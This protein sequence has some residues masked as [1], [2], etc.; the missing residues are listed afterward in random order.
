MAASSQGN[1]I[2]SDEN[3]EDDEDGEDDDEHNTDVD[4]DDF[5]KGGRPQPPSQRRGQQTGRWHP[6][7]PALWIW[8]ETYISILILNILLQSY[9]SSTII[10][11]K[12][13]LY[14]IIRLEHLIEILFKSSTI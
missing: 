14:F 13:E 5:D 2:A 8:R 7:L 3:G 10:N 4:K 9:F 6:D 11:M 12:S 1:R